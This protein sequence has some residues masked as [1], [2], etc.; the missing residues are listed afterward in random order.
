[1]YFSVEPSAAAACDPSIAAV[2]ESGVCGAPEHPATATSVARATPGFHPSFFIV[3]QLLENPVK[4]R[5]RR[6][7]A[8]EVKRPT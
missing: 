7:R 3:E 2:G 8:R 5:G 6:A 4:A 1:V